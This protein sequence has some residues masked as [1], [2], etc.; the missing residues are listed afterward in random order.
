MSKSCYECGEILKPYQGDIYFI[1]ALV[2][3]RE[4]NKLA[5]SDEKPILCPDEFFKINGDQKKSPRDIEGNMMFAI[6]V[7]DIYSAGGIPTTA[8]YG[9][10][11]F[12]S[13]Q[14]A[15]D[16]L[17]NATK[18]LSKTKVWYDFPF[19]EFGNPLGLVVEEV[20]D[21][22]YWQTIDK[23]K[24]LKSVDWVVDHLSKAMAVKNE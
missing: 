9:N 20:E 7:G 13:E 11:T 24:E 8:D 16:K 10:F 21:K 17:P 15:L 12:I 5:I 19:L 1:N 6:G 18:L 22:K 3:D 23:E 4:K 2:F 14:T